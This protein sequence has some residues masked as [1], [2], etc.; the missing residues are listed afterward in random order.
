[1]PVY[2]TRA[3]WEA[4][5][6]RLRKQILFAAGLEPMPERN[7][8]TPQIFGRIDNKDYSIEKVLLQT[9]PGYYLGGNLYR[10]IGKAG[11]LP[12]VLATHGH[13]TYGRLENQ[14]LCSV[15]ARAISLA[16]QGY[17]VFSYDMVGYNDTLQTPH[18]F[19][20]PREQLWSFGPLGLQLWNS[21]RAIDFVQALP[22]VDPEKIAMTGESGGGTQTFLATA[23]DNRIRYS[24]PVNMISAIMQGGSPCENAPGLRL[25]TSN[26]E[27]GALM[28]PRPM[29]M[30]AAT[31]DWTRNTPKE[32]YPALRSIYEL[33]DRTADL[34]MVQ[35]EAPHNYNRQSREAMY[36]FFGKRVLGAGEEHSFAERN[37]RVEPLQNMLAL[38]GR[39]LP[40]SALSYDK[41]VE[42]WISA[43]TRQSEETTQRQVLRER[44][45]LA[46]ASEWPAKVL[47]ERSGDRI[48][49][50][51]Q[52]RGDRVP[53]VWVEAG[54]QAALV[55][56]PDGA[57]AARRT[58]EAQ[59]M[60]RK[61]DSVLMIDAFQTGS[62]VAP[63]DRS[64]KHFLAFNQTDDACRAQD[65]LTA[66]AFLKQSGY[67]NI[68]LL[69]IGKA[70]AW[71][72]FA[73][74]V[75]EAPVSLETDLKG[76][77]G[78]D[79]DFLGNFFVPGIQRAG[80]MKAARVLLE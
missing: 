15:P 24:V 61:G 6:A 43:A 32:E 44:L 57:D 16:R 5:A 25:G 10:P 30:I 17:V 22:D 2:K 53:G 27:I 41:I 14:T 60:I 4:R 68:R 71:T 18:A 46:L 75:S 40:E 23:V 12:G 31:G 50:S 11:K 33:Y 51:R 63:R 37:I 3:Q 69:G 21:M 39:A 55:V 58:G 76:F 42:Q 72:L 38:H 45:A 54:K 20:S 52:G 1:M 47:G 70:A 65:I 36:R 13:W 78:S 59:A 7:A 34:E 49:L 48:V 29:L 56:H 8:L 67:A 62:A 35:I 73:A 64:V 80:G 28:A 74:A 9:L 77:T 19:G 66:L 26:L 79:A